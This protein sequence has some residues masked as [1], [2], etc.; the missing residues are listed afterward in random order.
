M[1]ERRCGQLRAF[2]GGQPRGEKAVHHQHIRRVPCNRLEHCLTHCWAKEQG[3]SHVPFL[4]EGLAR[5]PVWQAQRRKGRPECA[6]GLGLGWL[7]KDCD[8]V[9]AR[10]EASHEG[11]RGSGIPS[12]VPGDKKE[13]SACHSVSPWGL[14]TT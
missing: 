1:Y 11:I 6:N 2:G 14:C 13:A 10:H 3:Q 5:G 7:A 12:S 8:V 9:P 4:L